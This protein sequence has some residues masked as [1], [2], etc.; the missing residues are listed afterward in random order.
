MSLLI[1][2]PIFIAA[3][4]PPQSLAHIEPRLIS[5]FEWGLTLPLCL[6]EK[7]DLIK[8]LEKKSEVLGY[9][10]T[11]RA[12]Q[13]LSEAFSANPKSAIKAL[14]ALVLR[15]HL[16]SKNKA[17]KQAVATPQQIKVLLADLIEKEKEQLLS[18]DRILQ[19]VAEH[20]EIRSEDLI[21]KSQSRKYVVP[22]QIA[23]YLCR[24]LLKLPYMKIG[25]VFSKD[26]STVMSS[27]KQIEQELLRIESDIA[28]N[29]KAIK[30]QLQ[31]KRKSEPVVEADADYAMKPE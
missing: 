18:P 27:T 12:A 20:Y 3:N 29:V 23:M 21:A 31:T 26:H 5:R 14:D 25:D 19:A 8:L 10:L 6:P 22:R 11:I 15:T 1:G 4:V 7:K 30:L 9:P 28:A 17:I 13:Y 24:S 16:H 2:K